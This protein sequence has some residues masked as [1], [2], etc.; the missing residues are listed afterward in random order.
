[1]AMAFRRVLDATVIGGFAVG[2]WYRPT[3]DE[4]NDPLGPQRTGYMS[5]YSLTDMADKNKP[6]LYQLASDLVLLSTTLVARTFLY[7]LGTCTIKEDDNYES[8]LQ[9]VSDRKKGVPLI[10]VSNHRSLID[11]PVILSGILPW[12][13]AY[14]PKLS[15][16]AICTQ[17]YVFVKKVSIE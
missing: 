11:D 2:W 8:F 1:M 4:S 5:Q 15:R 12:Q 3:S 16:N 10:T 17:E 9:L 13:Y 6:F 7:N 14:Q